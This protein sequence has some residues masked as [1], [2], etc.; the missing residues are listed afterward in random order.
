MSQE[1]VERYKQEKANRKK[2]MKKAKIK[3]NLCKIGAGIVVILVLGAFGYSSYQS[4]L[5]KPVE[6]TADM[7]AFDEYVTGINAEE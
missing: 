5:M 1:K 4:Y 7:R 3:K 6:V 2:N